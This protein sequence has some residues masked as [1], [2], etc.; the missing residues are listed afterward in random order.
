[1]SHPHRTIIISPKFSSASWGINFTD[2]DDPRIAEDFDFCFDP[3]G[4][5]MDDD[6]E[7]ALEELQK[8]EVER[9]EQ[10]KKRLQRLKASEEIWEQGLQRFRELKTLALRKKEP[11][12]QGDDF[13]FRQLEPLLADD[14]CFA[15]EAR[16][17]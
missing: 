9:V 14:A 2:N 1:M 15:K 16:E 10:S 12:D 3:F 4:R 6:E 13:V 7:K 17:M 8:K 11:E 5:L